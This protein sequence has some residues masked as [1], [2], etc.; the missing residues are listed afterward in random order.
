ML[1]YL[2][3]LD[4]AF[5]VLAASLAIGVGV[6]ALLL[7]FHLDIAPEQR[8]S[9]YS[10]LILTAA[11]SAVTVAAAAGGWGIRKQAAWHWLAQVAFAA[12]LVLSYLI[13]IQMLA[14]Q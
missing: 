4:M 9:M 6:S 7:A 5:A 2:F 14:N 1:R 11:Y 10:L 8:D 13:S 12:L 3:I